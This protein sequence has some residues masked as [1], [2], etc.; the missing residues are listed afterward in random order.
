M[1]GFLSQQNLTPCDTLNRKLSCH[2]N[3]IMKRLDLERHEL[4]PRHFGHRPE[5]AIVQRG[6][7]NL[8]DKVCSAIVLI[9]AIISRRCSSKYATLMKRPQAGEV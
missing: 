2:F 4:V 7:A 1:L 6:L 5:D 8:S 9:A 3:H